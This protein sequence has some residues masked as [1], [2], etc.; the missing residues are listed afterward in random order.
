MSSPNK[1]R[2]LLDAKGDFAEVLKED[3]FF[4]C[5]FVREHL[6]NC[7]KPCGALSKAVGNF[8]PYKIIPNTL[9]PL[10]KRS[11]CLFVSFKKRKG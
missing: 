5:W 2:S 8:V 7:H 1:A 3:L 4:Q 11:N 6:P 9:G 10:A